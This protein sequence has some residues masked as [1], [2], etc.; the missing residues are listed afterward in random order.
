MATTCN[1]CGCSKAKCGCQDTMLTSPAPCPTPVGCP[2]PQPCS[3]VFD[4]QCSI[5]T[6]TDIKCIGNTV[7]AQNTNVADAIKDVVDFFC[8]YIA[9]INAGS[10]VESCNDYITVTSSI[11]PLSGVTIYEVCFDY[12]YLLDQ[13]PTNEFTAGG[14]IAI[15]SGTVG[16]VTTYTI[17]NTD[18]GSAQFIFKNIAVSGQNTIVADNNNDTLTVQAGSGISLA[19]DSSTD[20]LRIVNS[21][22]NVIQNVFTTFQATSGTTTANSPTDTLIVVGGDG[23]ST[24]ITA[25][26]LTITADVRKYVSGALSG[27]QV[28]THNLSTTD[29]VISI[30]EA[31][32]PPANAFVHGIDYLYSITN[33]N[34]VTI[35]ETSVGSLGTYRVT[36]MG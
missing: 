4:A 36:V 33:T 5:Y 32:I 21:S 11:D 1:N 26:T 15:T 30:I 14:G 23:I 17:D 9:E 35:T 28:V 29:V 7:V 31:V 6:G 2:D 10:V 27:N 12:D 20:T 25:D 24:S 18:K 19:T 16:N 8:S 3:E 34:Q 22:P 13:L